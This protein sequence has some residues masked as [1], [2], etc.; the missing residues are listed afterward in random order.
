MAVSSGFKK[1]GPILLLGVIL[2]L[3]VRGVL[4]A[5]IG[6]KGVVIINN[7]DNELRG[8]VHFT[9]GPSFDVILAPG[10]NVVG[11]FE[12]GAT[13]VPFVYKLSDEF[14]RRYSGEGIG[15]VAPSRQ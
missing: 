14:G 8:S 3:G 13:A 15:R 7:S 11:S 12:P 4:M 6:V 2:S 1:I 5:Q 9:R 10:R